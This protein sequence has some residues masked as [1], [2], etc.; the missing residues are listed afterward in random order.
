MELAEG[1]SLYTFLE[2][3]KITYKIE[4]ALSWALQVAR[5]IS[6]MHQM[7]PNAIIH[8]DIKPGNILL[9]D[10][11]RKV[12][13]CDFGLACN[14][15]E[16]MT[17]ERG[18]PLWMA[19][20]VTTTGKYSEKCD[21]FSWAVTFWQMLTRKLPGSD[22]KTGNFYC[23]AVAIEGHRP[24]LIQGCPE[25]LEKLIVKS[26]AQKADDRIDSSQL[27]GL[28]E[29]IYATFVPQP[30]RPIYAVS[31]ELYADVNDMIIE[32]MDEFYDA[33]EYKDLKEIMKLDEQN[34]ITSEYAK[35]LIEEEILRKYKSDWEK[36]NKL[37]ITYEIFEDEVDRNR[38]QIQ[39]K[40][41]ELAKNILGLE[42]IQ[43]RVSEML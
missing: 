20:E 15:K 29:V 43:K 24:P 16:Y 6:Y 38:E 23:Y 9:Q 18:T 40:E 11:C 30:P 36:W 5:G 39:R 33:E 31:D 26:W 21:V 22:Y 14:Y 8:R 32:Y 19:P 17:R 37:G 12:K 42:H 41:E 10:H 25:F 28:M 7:K 27:V 2:K 35:L 4:H 3:S 1:G 34:E 13:I